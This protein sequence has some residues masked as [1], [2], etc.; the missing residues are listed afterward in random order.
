VVKVKD[1]KVI[2][3]EK[4]LVA[5]AKQFVV[6]GIPAYNEESSISRVIL[7]AQKFADV[8]VVC[9]DGS[10]DLTAE[11]AKRLGAEVVRHE[12]RLGYGAAIKSLFERARELEAD[13]LVTLDGDGQHDPMEIPVVLKPINDGMAD[14]V[15]GSRFVDVSRTVEMPMYRRI[16][17]KLI[18]KLV[19][20]SSKNGVRDAQSG[21]R[22][23][24]RRALEQLRIVESGMGA[25]V[26]ILLEAAKHDLKIYEVPS[27]CKYKNG[28]GNTS[29]EHPISH[30][31]SVVMSIVRFIVEE[32][33]LMVLGLPGIL[34][35]LAGIGFGVWMMQ[36][37]AIE[38]RIVTNVALASLSFVIIGFFMLS[39]AITLYA[40]SRISKRTNGRQ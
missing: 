25:S 9:D 22:A 12:R 31:I 34:C 3:A 36:L 18:T 4:V 39:T 11:I 13:V 14:V 20:G 21:F 16:G 8:V 32:K 26:E 27:S 30:G 28:K 1:T 37:Y 38:H 29:T 35:L 17:A 7:K 33:P 23:Y 15:I 5:E 24:D 10:A 2:V 40:I 6:V 19:N